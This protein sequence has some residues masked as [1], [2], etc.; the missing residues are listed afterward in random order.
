MAEKLLKDQVVVITGAGGL[1]GREFAA[2]AAAAGARV[3]L[4]DI[5][6]AAKQVAAGL[7]K[8]FGAGTALFV[9]LDITSKT[10]VTAAITAIKKTFGRIDA[11]VNS[12]YPRNKNYGRKFEAVEYKDFCENVNL[13]LGGYFLVSQQFAEFFKKQGGG[14]IINISSVYGVAA[15][16]FQIYEGTPM[17]MPVEYAAI[18]SA[19]IMLTQY[20]ARY[21]A[22][23]NIR[24][25]A[26]S[27]GGILDGQPKAFLK[28]YRAL[29]LNKGMLDR[30]DI[31][32]TVLYLLSG[33]SRYVNG[34]NIIVDD[35]FLL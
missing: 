18:K 21:Y 25:N 20:M 10:S 19:V 16:R 8:R 2:A 9:S 17:T 6:P 30:S 24:F 22:N 13:H 4:A 15:P 28:A 26:V 35:G 11:V 23:C 14:N 5:S 12:A 33:L 29:C 3:A 34:Q 27:A 7:N 1:L 32:G 31:S